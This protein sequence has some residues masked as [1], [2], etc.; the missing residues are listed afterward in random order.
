MRAAVWDP[1]LY[2]MQLSS[3]PQDVAPSAKSGVTSLDQ[4][5][6]TK[7]APRTPTATSTKTTA[8]TAAVPWDRARA[9][10]HRLCDVAE[11]RDTLF[12]VY[13]L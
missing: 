10:H 4:T 7:L 9:E 6:G 13:D 12:N 3:T 1:A 11:L 2:S 5:Q 8:V